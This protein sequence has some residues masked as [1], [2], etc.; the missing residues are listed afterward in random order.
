MKIIISGGSGLIGSA[1]SCALSSTG[2]DVVKLVRDPRSDHENTVFWDPY[3]GILDR[4]VLENAE[5]LIHL[6]GANIAS[7]R[8]T[9]KRK[10]EILESRV[11]TTEFLANALT[12]LRNPPRVWLCASAVGY[13]GDRG[14]EI[15]TEDAPSGSGFLCEV[16]SAWEKKTALPPGHNT[17]VVNLRFGGV[18]DRQGGMLAR[19]L[20]LFRRGLGGVLG[21]GTQYMSWIT[22]RD[23]V[24]AVETVISDER[25]SGPVN[26]VAPEPV[27]N[28]EFTRSL[29]KIL[30]RPTVFHAPAPL[31]RLVLGELADEL[32]L[33]STRA[34]PAKLASVGFQFRDK[35]LLDAWSALL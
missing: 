28:R 3:A 19:L 10:R 12:Q 29:G 30:R 13:Y 32:L 22:L 15:L 5:A 33:A 31:L 27:T 8:W 26:V 21:R 24:R 18:L 35:T 4:S 17:R 1:I 20:P 34:V 16:C 14:D 11:K 2:Y 7:G 6:S 25:L 23:V 9:D